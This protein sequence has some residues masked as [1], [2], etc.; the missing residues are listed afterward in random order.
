MNDL[1]VM[2]TI[3][4]L[5][6]TNNPISTTDTLQRKNALVLLGMRLR[7]V[8]PVYASFYTLNYFTFNPMSYLGQLNEHYEGLLIL[9]TIVSNQSTDTGLHCCPLYFATLSKYIPNLTSLSH[10]FT[11]Y[12]WSL[13]R[14]V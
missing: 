13:R 11:S 6:T 7:V 3:S 4:F 1:S 10:S 8:I 5:I 2:P 12:L 14:G 9:N